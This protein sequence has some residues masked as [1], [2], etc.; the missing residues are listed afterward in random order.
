VDAARDGD[1]IF[2]HP[3][4]HRLEPVPYADP[5]CGNCPDPLTPVAATRGLLVQGKSVVIRGASAHTTSLHTGAGYGILIVDCPRVLITDLAVTGGERDEDPK[6]TDG[7]VVVRRSHVTLRRNR[8]VHNVG[9]PEIRMDNTVGIIG[10]AGREGA[11]I[12]AEDNTI[13]GNSWDGVA[14]YRDARAVLLRNRIDGGDTLTWGRPFGGRGVGVGITWNAR[15]RLRGNWISRYWKGVGVFVDGRAALR[16]NVVEEMRTWGVALWRGGGEGRPRLVAEGN[17]IYRTGAC[18][19]SAPLADPGGHDLGRFTGNGIFVTGRDPRYDRP[20]RYCRQAPIALEGE[21]E[22][23][24][25]RPFVVEDNLL[26]RNR[27]TEGRGVEAEI[28]PDSIPDGAL[29][30]LGLCRAAASWRT[31]FHERFCSS[32]FR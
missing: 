23:P 12:R 11:R 8:I 31:A 5:L 13:F 10:I 28:G 6:A 29:R 32:L 30:R 21:G 26:Y 27:R 4:V 14:L 17:V 24:E 2:L 15:A 3:G 18:G 16:R 1:T 19:L 20:D 22:G 9:D 25:S 7:A